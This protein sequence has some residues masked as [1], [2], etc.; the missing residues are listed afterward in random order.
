MGLKEKV[1]GTNREDKEGQSGIEGE[2][3]PSYRQMG[4]PDLA[5]PGAVPSIKL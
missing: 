5:R 2:L 4:V 1:E 3:S